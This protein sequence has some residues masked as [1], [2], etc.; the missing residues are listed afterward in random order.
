[1]EL[2]EG[3]VAEVEGGVV[4]AALAGAAVVAAEV[5]LAGCGGFSPANA[6]TAPRTSDR[7]T[8]ANERM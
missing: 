1:V 3:A 6:V 5:A 7:D 2:V 4:G 8:K